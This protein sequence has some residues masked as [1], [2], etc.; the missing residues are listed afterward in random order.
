MKAV[1]EPTGLS[2]TAKRRIGIE[3]NTTLNIPAVIES[4]SACPENPL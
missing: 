4:T 3:L 1:S 2:R